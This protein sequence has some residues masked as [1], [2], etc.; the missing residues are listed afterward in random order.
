MAANILLR[1]HSLTSTLSFSRLSAIAA[2]Q[3][4]RLSVIASLPILYS[5]RSCLF[6]L[7]ITLDIRQLLGH[8]LLAAARGGTIHETAESY[9]QLCLRRPSHSVSSLSRSSY[10]KPS[11][12]TPL[13]ST[14]T[15]WRPTYIP[16]ARLAAS[17]ASSQSKAVPKSQ[18][19]SR[20]TNGP[21]V[22]PTSVSP[23][24]TPEFPSTKLRST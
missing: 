5:Y 22:T 12:S 23:S 9:S 15:S 8:C 24:G 7:A 13:A 21:V 16:N 11:T 18:T 1:V 20:G 2:A 14:T 19:S 17:L 10:A 4:L 6:A 3:V